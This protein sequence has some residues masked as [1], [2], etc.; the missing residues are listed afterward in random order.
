LVSLG[1]NEG[2]AGELGN[3][4]P[5]FLIMK[6]NILII[7]NDQL[8]NR[9]NQKVLFTADIVKEIH[10]ALNGQEAIEHLKLR[11]LKN[12][13]LPDLII[14]DLHLPVMNGFEFLDELHKIDFHGKEKIDLAVFTN[15]HSLN[16]RQK[17]IAR[18]VKHYLSKP[19]L[20]RGLMSILQ[21]DS[22]PGHLLK[23]EKNRS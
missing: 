8:L 1:I 18:G 13:P 4:S 7:D 9:I 12:K 19:Y 5:A 6:K 3:H 10:F 15:S 20:L 23:V 11:L 14:L 22:W 2:V 16:D 17:A 21:K